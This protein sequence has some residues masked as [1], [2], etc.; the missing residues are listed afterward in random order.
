MSQVEKQTKIWFDKSI[1]LYNQLSK[2]RLK[3]ENIANYYSTHN[4][5]KSV[6]IDS[7][8]YQRI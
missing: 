3:D 5:G 4:K 6:I 1:E 2:S 8:K 7:I